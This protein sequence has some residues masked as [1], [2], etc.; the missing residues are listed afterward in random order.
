MNIKEL[1]GAVEE[2]Q[3]QILLSKLSMRKAVFD[4]QFPG[5]VKNVFIGELRK[6]LIFNTD[7]ETCVGLQRLC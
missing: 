3:G 1:R 7:V 6:R 5:P 2:G 4:G